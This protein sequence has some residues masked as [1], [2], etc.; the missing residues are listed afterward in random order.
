MTAPDFEQSVFTNCPFDKDYEPILQAIIFCILY[1]GF[2]PRLASERGDAGEIRLHKI[3][4]CIKASKYSIHDLSR[5]QAKESG[6]FFRLNMPFELGIDFGCREFDANERRTKKFLILDEKK[7]RYQAALSDLSGCDIQTHQGE[8][9]K[10][11]GKVRSW[12]VN[13]AGAKKI[14]AS[15][16]AGKYAD[17]QAWY[18]E[19][20]KAA[21]SSE[22]DIKDYPTSEILTNM[23]R[24]IEQGEPLT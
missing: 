13:D 2:I 15:K 10:A 14:G 23:K 5:S 17:F 8:F 24:W 19:T 4:E 20:Q 7:H 9:E 6:E 22:H 11:I 16:V 21:G 1:F 3:V 18:W 12:L